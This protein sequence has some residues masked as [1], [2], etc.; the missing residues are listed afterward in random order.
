[1]KELTAS[2]IEARSGRAGRHSRTRL[3]TRLQTRLQMRLRTWLR[4]WQGPCCAA[5]C[6]PGCGP[7]RG[8]DCR[9]GCGPGCGP[10]CRHSLL[11]DDCAQL[12]DAEIVSQGPVGTTQQGLGK[13]GVENTEFAAAVAAERADLAETGN[14]L[15]S[16]TACQAASESCCAR[17][18]SNHGNLSAFAEELKVLADAT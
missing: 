3:W 14:C 5:G 13:A 18:A 4:T 2:L 1:M 7:G 16:F 15:A 8:P 11:R 9:C 6:G 10:G 17:V 12:R